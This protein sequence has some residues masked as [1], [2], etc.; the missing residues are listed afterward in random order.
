MVGAGRWRG[1]LME[2]LKQVEED[3]KGVQCSG[4]NI[5]LYIGE[6]SNAIDLD[7]PTRLFT[8]ELDNWDGFHLL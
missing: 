7:T 5:G 3:E 8:Q 4:H 2:R 6:L 1:I